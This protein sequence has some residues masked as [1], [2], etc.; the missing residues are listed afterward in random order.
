M[1]EQ[2]RNNMMTLVLLVVLLFAFAGCRTTEYIE[3]PVTHTEYVYRD[4][5]DSVAVHDSVFI[6]EYQRGDTVRVVEYR[7]KD[8]FRYIQATDTIIQR[9]TVSVVRPQ[10]V[11]RVEYRTRGMVKILAWLG[12][13]GLLALAAYLYLRF[14][15]F[16]RR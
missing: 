1:R 4:R 11:E 9:D 13:A 6:K 10:V 5:V 12:V 14:K 7:Y 2:K 15:V 8:R 3:V 16:F